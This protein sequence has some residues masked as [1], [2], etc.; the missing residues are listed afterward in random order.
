MHFFSLL[1]LLGPLVAFGIVHGK[2]IFPVP[3]KI[4][5]NYQGNKNIQKEVLAAA[6]DTYHSSINMNKKSKDLLICVGLF[7]IGQFLRCTF[8]KSRP[9]TTWM[10]VRVLSLLAAYQWYTMVSA[11]DSYKRFPCL[12]PRVMM[13]KLDFL[14]DCKS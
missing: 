9:D 10:S 11:V 13:K 6:T 1:Q 3:M 12:E 7:Q 2:P 8:S 4:G 14:K 5:S